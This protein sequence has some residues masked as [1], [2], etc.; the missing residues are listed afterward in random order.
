MHITN[1][2]LEQIALQIEGHTKHGFR[3]YE[4]PALL[5]SLVR[6]AQEPDPS[7]VSST[8]T[9]SKT[10]FSAKDFKKAFDEVAA[11]VATAYGIEQPTPRPTP[12]TPEDIREMVT[13]LS[14]SMDDEWFHGLADRINLRLGL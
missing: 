6:E 2:R 14:P 9:G 3:C 13:I 8:P 12:I 4:I 11:A 7:P 5:R 10:E 1:E